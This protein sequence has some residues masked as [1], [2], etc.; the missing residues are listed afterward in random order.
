MGI[1][2]LFTTFQNKA[3]TLAC[4]LEQNMADA[5]QHWQLWS[6]VFWL[7]EWG[8]KENSE[9]ILKVVQKKAGVRLFVNKS[10]EV[11]G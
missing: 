5:I 11:G 2:F 9:T 6:I 7:E 8:E 4:E 1:I 3:I 10:S